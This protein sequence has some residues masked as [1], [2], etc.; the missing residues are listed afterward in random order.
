MSLCEQ[1]IAGHRFTKG[2]QSIIDRCTEN[3]YR[4]YQESNYT[5]QP[6]T[7]ADFRNELL[8]QPEREARSLALEL[9]LFT[10][11]SLNTFAKQTNVDTNSRILCYAL[12][13]SSKFDIIIE[14]FIQRRN[15]NIFEINEALF[16]FDQ[17]LL[18][19]G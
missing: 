6:P 19:A 1:I 9:E 18:G 11:G 15:Y 2:Q 4:E 12:S 10:K 14:Y 8:K 5:I 7:L 13:H 16:A 17:S 3:V